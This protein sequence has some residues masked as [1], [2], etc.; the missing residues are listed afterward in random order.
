[1]WT[2]VQVRLLCSRNLLL[3]FIK[4]IAPWL[5]ADSLKKKKILLL[6][7]LEHRGLKFPGISSTHLSEVSQTGAFGSKKEG[8]VRLKPGQ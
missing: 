8:F 1:M 4:V 5:S 7:G 6:V 3:V 2:F